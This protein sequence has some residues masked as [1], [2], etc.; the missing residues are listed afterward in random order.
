MA[1]TLIHAPGHDRAKSLGWIAVA[2]IEFFLVYGRGGVTGQPVRLG[3]EAVGYIVDC[4]ACGDTQKRLYDSAFFSRP[5]GADKS[6]IAAYIALFEAL[7]PARPATDEDGNVIYAEGG[8]TY[9]DPYGLGFYYEY[10]PGEPIGIHLQSPMIRCMATEEGQSGNVFET[11]YY[12]LTLG[13]LAA[14][15]DRDSAGRTRI[16]LP[17]TVGPK[18]GSVIPSTAAAASK[19]GGLETFV[20][21]DEGHLYI[22]PE[23]RRAYDTVKRNLGKRRKEGTWLLETTTMY[24]PGE[25]SVAEATYKYASLIEEGKAKRARLLFDHRWGEIDPDD[26]GDEQKLRAALVEAYGDAAAWVDIEGL[27]DDILDPR[28]GM[29]DSLRYFLNSLTSSENAWMEYHA[30]RARD[31]EFL[32]DSG[33]DVPTLPAPGDVIALGFDGSRSRARGVTDATALIATRIADGLQW[34]IGVWEQPRGALNWSVP[35]E[36]VEAAI[37]SAFERYNV[38]A[39]YADPAKW[40]TRVAEWEAKYSKQLKVKASQAHPIQWWMIGETNKR[41][42]SALEEYRSAV[43]DGELTHLNSPAL[44]RHVLA[45]RMRP[46]RAGVQIAKENP[47][48]DRKIDAAVA[49]VISWRARTDALAKGLGKRKAT[50]IPRRIR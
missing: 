44:T 18:G 1:R 46:S 31:I 22:T 24:A 40:E 26:M 23:L 16:L 38:V 30:W 21:I 2:W 34:E 28:S 42:V 3:D 8:E 14:A 41:T 15:M 13:P 7:G 47:S 17:K 9:E 25:D 19:D 36:E 43:I 20:V 6:G 27:I 32:R 12:N 4:Y 45:A 33:A 37:A 35:V 50:V 29:Q 11:I 10:Q 49:A 5:K 48:S 39:F